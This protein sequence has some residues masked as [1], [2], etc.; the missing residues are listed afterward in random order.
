M[1]TA[2]PAPPIYRY[3]QRRG[4]EFIYLGPEP[5]ERTPGA[6]CTRS[7]RLPDK[8]AE[9]GGRWADPEIVF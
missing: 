4:A 6:T 1:T 8:A 7:E 3:I 5:P 2:L 9:W